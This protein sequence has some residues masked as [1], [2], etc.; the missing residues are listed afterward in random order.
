MVTARDFGVLVGM[1]A[2]SLAA[3]ALSFARLEV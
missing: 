2:A 3:A 1:A